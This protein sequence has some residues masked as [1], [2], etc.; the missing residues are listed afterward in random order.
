MV[1]KAKTHLLLSNLAQA[2]LKVEFWKDKMPTTEKQPKDYVQFN[3]SIFANAGTVNV[4]PKK[5][6]FLFY[7][8]RS[9]KPAEVIIYGFVND[10]W[11]PQDPALYLKSAPGK[12]LVEFEETVSK[13]IQ[14][15][16]N[17]GPFVVEV[18][19]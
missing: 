8:G 16:K 17:E 15:I 6:Y 4:V 5:V 19:N 10:N 2:Q 18:V 11:V 13:Q 7:K 3:I 14:L 12:V 9:K 1:K